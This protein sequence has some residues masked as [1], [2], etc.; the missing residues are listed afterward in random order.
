MRSGHLV[1]VMLCVLLAPPIAAWGG[2]SSQAGL[3]HR[4]RQV[5][6]PHVT[7]D[8]P[9]AIV[10]VARDGVVVG[11]CAMGYADVERKIPIDSGTVFDLASC[12]KQ[13]T[14]VGIMILADRG[15]LAIED[16]ARKFLPELSVR[17]PPIRICDL[18]HMTSGLPDY[19]KLLDHLEDKTNLDVLHAVAARP[20]LFQAGSKFNYCD[21]N[22]VLL[23]TIVERVSGRKFAQ[24]L[25]SEIFDPAGMKQSVVL[26]APGQSIPHRAEGYSRNKEGK[27]KPSREDT[28]TYG[29]GQ[30]M[31]TALDLLKWDAALRG[32][33]LVKPRTLAL[34]FTSGT[35][36]DGKP[37]G[38]GFGWY[39]SQKNGRTVEHGGSWFGTSTHILR[40]LDSG[41]TIIVLSNLQQFP[42]E[43]VCSAVAAL[44][45]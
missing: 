41:V 13:F 7:G 16:D 40:Q 27:I 20:L 33:T 39:V 31:T 11:Q 45:E 29:D 30:V 6:A 34:A 4:I 35:L 9:G 43:K 42:A 32:N 1:A 44:A 36:S 12:S 14:A 17:Q 21:T 3:S 23:A 8:G 18:L 25:Q 10:V 26:E 28:R 24:F 19:E 15:K 22:Y 37:C 38:Y 5:L 2:T